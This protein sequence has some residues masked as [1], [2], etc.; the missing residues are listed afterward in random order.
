L[1][2]VKKVIALLCVVGMLSAQSRKLDL[3]TQTKNGLPF[4]Q[5]NAYSNR[6]TLAEEFI[7]AV[8]TDESIGTYGWELITGTGGSLNMAVSA[9]LDHPGIVEILSGTTSGNQTVLHLGVTA[10]G[11]F[12]PD[13]TFTSEWVV[14]PDNTFPITNAQWRFGFG[15][16]V[17]GATPTA[18]IYFEKLAGD[19]NWFG[20]C[21]ASST[22]TRVDTGEAVAQAYALFKIRRVNASTIGFTADNQTEVTCNTNVP[23]SAQALFAASKTADTTDKQLR[24]DYVSLSFTVTR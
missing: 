2:W 22:E 6:F 11:L 9:V 13:E 3:T 21:R 18:G 14:Y 19:T 20:V 16:A 1:S 8:G 17:D 12:D 5:S 23:G 7:S 10:G 15:R 24:L 4:N